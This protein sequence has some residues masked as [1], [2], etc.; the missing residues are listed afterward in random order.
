MSRS[1]HRE[2][3]AFALI[4]SFTPD[5]YDKLA[6]VLEKNYYVGKGNFSGWINLPVSKSIWL[7]KA[8][9]SDVPIPRN[10][11]RTGD[12]IKTLKELEMH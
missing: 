6:D 3:I 9:R 12:V 8:N 11:L 10:I 2:R 7:L 4:K 1:E 5:K